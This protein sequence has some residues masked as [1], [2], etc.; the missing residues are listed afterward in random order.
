MGGVEGIV[1]LGD[2]G[3]GNGVDA[4]NFGSPK[5]RR[6]AGSFRATRVNLGTR[7]A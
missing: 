3:D 6:A 5:D 4:G 2:A 7:G 1:D